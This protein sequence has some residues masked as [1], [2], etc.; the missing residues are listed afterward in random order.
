[1]LKSYMDFFYKKNKLL[2]I[3]LS[4]F[5]L[6]SYVFGL[7]V[8]IRR[9]LY[10]KGFIKSYD[11]GIPV[12]SIGNITVGGTG[13]T[14]MVIHLSN[15]VKSNRPG[16]VSR[17]YKGHARIMIDVSD[18]NKILCP[19]ELCGDE[20]YLISV[21]TENAIVAA[22][23]N[24][25]RT[26]KHIRETYD[27]SIIILDDGFSHLKVKRDIEIL[28]IDGESGFGNGHLLPAGPL[29]EPLKTLQ[30]ADIIGIKGSNENL[31]KI[32]R[33]YNADCPIFYFSYKFKG[34]KNINDNQVIDI[35]NIMQ[36][37]VV[38]MA[39]IALPESFFGMLMAVGLGLYKTISK[40]DHHNY[41]V[42]ELE[43]VV[44]DHQPDVVIV[45]QKD[46][47]KI[48]QLHK[49]ERVMWLY[50]DMDIDTDDVL[51]K[52]MLHNKGMEIQ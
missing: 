31:I 24:R 18:G 15:L 4:P 36:K 13:K 8:V 38:A 39:G 6:L 11:A 34:F 3:L 46:A 22:G 49:N 43:K 2:D 23:K 25:V 17:G 28:L 47:V 42:G 52:D 33:K 5:I 12:I 29:R 21:C 35:T 14:P 7:I 50:T 32:I 1:M 45:T 48:H 16:I 30:Y 44:H 19:P 26:I 27:P 20:P 37:R 51:L 9:Y 40:P 41:K 10:I